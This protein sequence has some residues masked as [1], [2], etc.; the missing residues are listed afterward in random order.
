M[1]SVILFFGSFDPIHNGH[2][3]LAKSASLSLNSEVIFE[4]SSGGESVSET[5]ASVED[6]EKMIRLAL[7]EDGSPA[8]SYVFSVAKHGQSEEEG[9]F[10]AVYDYH[11]KHK[12]DKIY[13]LLGAEQASS[14]STWKNAEAIAEAASIVY[15]PSANGGPDEETVAR[16]RMMRLP[17]QSWE[18]DYPIVSSEMIRSLHSVDLPIRVREYIEK[19]RLYYASC[20]AKQMS[21]HRLRHSISVANLAYGIALRNSLKDPQRAYIAGLLHDMAKGMPIE[22]QREIMNQ[23][24]PEYVGLPEWSYHQFVGSYLAKK[25]FG[26]TDETI[27]MAVRFHA[28]GK[29]HMTPLGK[30]IYASDKIDPLRGY[31]SSGL[32][33]A[34]NRNYYVGFVDVLQANREYLESKGYYSD[35][36]PLTRDCFRLYLEGKDK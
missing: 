6:R 21:E 19:K 29:P 33:D 34:C 25:E 36:N 3:R 22:E 11:H 7:K 35:D 15:V 24:F 18:K 16:Y 27:L 8:F 31:D 12:K 26:I 5:K 13:L 32:I 17:K 28:T 10:Q 2:L 23:E 30:I 14:F 4:L 9:A 20:L 1:D